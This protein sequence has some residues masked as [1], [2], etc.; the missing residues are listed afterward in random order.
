MYSKPPELT[1]FQEKMDRTM[2][3]LEFGKDFPSERL[4]RDFPAAN[5]KDGDCSVACVGSGTAHFR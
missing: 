4:T 5:V 1:A 3:Q 2:T